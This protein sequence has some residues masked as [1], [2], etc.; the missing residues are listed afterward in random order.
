[1]I[2]RLLCSL[3]FGIFSVFGVGLVAMMLL[4]ERLEEA[5]VLLRPDRCL[6]SGPWII[7]DVF[8]SMDFC[9]IFTG[10]TC[11]IMTVGVFFVFWIISGPKMMCFHEILSYNLVYTSFSRVGK[12]FLT[13]IAAATSTL[14]LQNILKQ[15][16]ATPSSNL[17]ISPCHLASFTL[18]R[19]TTPSPKQ[20]NPGVQKTFGFLSA[21]AGAWKVRNVCTAFSSAFSFCTSLVSTWKHQKASEPPNQLM[22]P[23]WS[24]P[25]YQLI[26]GFSEL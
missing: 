24:L 13:T 23:F 22:F 21:P 26:T 18:H 6:T 19:P 17:T 2:S 20:D 8:F 7:N 15:L 12:A 25:F 4:L 1:M 5:A 16:L 11:S 3:C 14:I 10:W 9:P